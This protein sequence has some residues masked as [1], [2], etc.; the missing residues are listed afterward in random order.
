MR[1]K[2]DE[3]GNSQEDDRGY[4]DFPIHGR[5]SKCFAGYSMRYCNKQVLRQSIRPKRWDRMPVRPKGATMVG[6][7][8]AARRRTA[9]FAMVGMVVLLLGAPQKSAARQQGEADVA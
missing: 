2:E 3:E 6:R 9:E 5:T 8:P 4:E 1:P 7:G